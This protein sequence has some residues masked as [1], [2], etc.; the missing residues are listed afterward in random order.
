MYNPYEKSAFLKSCVPR[1]LSYYTF[2]YA[3]YNNII[4]TVLAAVPTRSKFEYLYDGRFILLFIYN[5]IFRN[6]FL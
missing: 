3:Y 6:A 5:I 1:Y 4:H 2:I